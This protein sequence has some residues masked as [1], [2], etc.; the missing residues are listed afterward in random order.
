MQFHGDVTPQPIPPSAVLVFGPPLP[1]RRA[2]ARALERKL[3]GSMRVRGGRRG[4]GLRDLAAAVAKGSLP[5]VE[6]DLRTATERGALYRVLRDAGVHPVFVAWLTESADAKREIYRRYAS[7]PRRY[8][9]HW[10]RLWLDDAAR[11]EPLASEVPPEALTFAGAHET[12]ADQ[13]EFVASSLGVAPRATASVQKRVLVV[14][15]EPD[16]REILAAALT[17]LGCEVHQARDAYEA[18]GVADRVPLDLVVTDERMPGVTGVEL[19]RELARRHSEIHVALV[20]GHADEI[21]ERAARERGVELLF[22]KPVRAADLVRLLDEI[23][24]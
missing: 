9:D 12:H 8:A 11:R 7:L 10:W 17:E 13:V 15:D 23:T 18:L 16:Q 5:I 3:P 1:G 14:D 20:T 21:V 22:A 6:A 2:L 19:A 24:D 4:V